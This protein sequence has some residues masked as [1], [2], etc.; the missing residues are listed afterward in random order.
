[1]AT[2]NPTSGRRQSRSM[3]GGREKS[4]KASLVQKLPRTTISQPTTPYF[5]AGYYCF[6]L[7]RSKSRTYHR[8]SQEF[9]KVI[10]LRDN[11]SKLFIF[12]WQMTPFGSPFQRLPI[13]G[14]YK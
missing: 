12:P 7:R 14:H 4:I 6:Q 10:I 9:L 13:S 8:K 2:D 11:L 1:M 3:Y 5:V